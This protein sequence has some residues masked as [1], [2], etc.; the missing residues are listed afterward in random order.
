[1]LGLLLLHARQPQLFAGADM[2]VWVSDW[3]GKRTE[4]EEKK[5]EKVSQPVD[6]AAQAKRQESRHKKVQDGIED[7]LL[8]LKDNHLQ[9]YLNYQL[10]I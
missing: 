4:R 5:E 3:L 6:E 1:M 7:L 8:W 10:Q 2:P 9:I